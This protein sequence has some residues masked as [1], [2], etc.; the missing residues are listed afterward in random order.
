LPTECRA[1]GIFKTAVSEG[2][3]H[4]SL[5]STN[6]NRKT[7]YNAKFL[8]KYKFKNHLLS[9]RAVALIQKPAPHWE[10]VFEDFFE[11]TIFASVDFISGV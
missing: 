5:E 8:G 9:G 7:R 10:T 1:V 4:A 3:T 11:R 6:K 2:D